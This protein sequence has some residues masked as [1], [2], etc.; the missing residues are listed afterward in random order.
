MIFFQQL[1]FLDYFLTKITW[2]AAFADLLAGKQFGFRLFL[3]IIL[4]EVSPVIGWT[5]RCESQIS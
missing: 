2:A 4:C 3:S 5:R 1:L